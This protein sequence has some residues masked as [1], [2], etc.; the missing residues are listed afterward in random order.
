E[1]KVGLHL[2]AADV[3][4]NV[5]GGVRVDEP[6]LDLPIALA[7]A[8]SLRDR[9]V[10]AH[11]VAFGEIGLVGE[12]RGVARAQARLAE[13]AQMGFRR[14]IVPRSIGEAIDRGTMEVVPVRT[15]EEALEA[16]G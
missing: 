11:V 3:F 15:L 1:R 4:V 12:V 6:A 10:F 14:A 7:A 5:A 13:A 16:C 2:A 8:S 9:A